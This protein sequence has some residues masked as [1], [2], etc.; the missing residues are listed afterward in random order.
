M[1]GRFILFMNNISNHL[2][3]QTNRLK[4][5]AEY[6]CAFTTTNQRE[7]EGGW[8]LPNKQNKKENPHVRSVIFL[9]LDLAVPDLHLHLNHTW[10]SVIFIWNGLFAL[11]FWTFPVL[12]S[13]DLLHPEVAGPKGEKRCDGTLRNQ[14]WMTLSEV[15]LARRLVLNGDRWSE[16]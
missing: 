9:Q 5:E 10:S 1:E 14:P 15:L 13:S 12:S 8:N 3:L 4:P 7:T 16:S 11:L 6:S 2:Y